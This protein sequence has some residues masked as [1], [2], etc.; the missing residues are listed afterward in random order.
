MAGSALA[1]LAASAQRPSSDD[2][3]TLTLRQAADMIATG[4]TSP[5]ELTRACLDR[6][7][8]YDPM[9]NAFITVAAERALATA[10]DM[11]AELARG[12]RRGPLHGIP[13]ALKDNI[14]TAGLRT[15]GASAL[16]E[17]RVPTEDAE[18]ARRLAE[19]G[20]VLLG[21]LNLHEFAYGG[22]S[23][24]THFGTMHNPWALDRA[25]GGS[26]GGP[27]AAVAADLCYAALGTD[28]AGSVRIPAA[29]C[30]IVGLK[31]TYG[32]VSMRGV[33]TLSWTL[34]HVGPM[35]KTVEDAALVLNAIAGY[36]PAD[37]TTVDRPVPDYTQALRLDTRRLRVGVPRAPFWED[38]DPDVEAAVGEALRVVA[39]L[40]AGTVDVSLPPVEVTGARLWGPEAYAYHLP[41]ITS[42]P[43][44][45]QPSTRASL[46]RYADAPALDYVQARR[47]VDLARRR[48]VALF[49]EVDLLV[50]PTMRQPPPPLTEPAGGGNNAAVFDL[51][52]VPAI[53]LPCGFT[54]AGL[55]IGVQIVGGPFAESTVLA[56][57]HAY[58]RATE[59]HLRKPPLDARPS[60]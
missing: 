21:K 12:R 53:S 16:F 42:S 28:T 49:S 41:W 10:R 31:P 2:L 33:L 38:L 11:E 34:D 9:L 29:Y 50:T 43:E 57:A 47:E 44:K 52:G 4:A 39:D 35:C 19:A 32:L 14:D 18:V 23:T 13:I 17:E 7:A 59:W 3:T 24:V 8:R 60:A 46:T 20:A 37:P 51:F 1:P 36:D 15:T 56:L 55:P 25:T 27:G 45:Y 30:G 58:E 22:S 6:I 5:T 48:I 40:T 26:S 54:R